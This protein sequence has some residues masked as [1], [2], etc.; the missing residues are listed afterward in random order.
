[1]SRVSASPVVDGKSEC[2]CTV[3]R[4]SSGTSDHY[5]T[6][7]SR[8]IRNTDSRIASTPSSFSSSRFLLLLHLVSLAT[9]LASS[10]P[11]AAA[12]EF[13]PVFDDI[14]RLKPKPP[15]ARVSPRRFLPPIRVPLLD[16]STRLTDHLEDSDDIR[17][18]ET[19]VHE[20]RR[21]E[22]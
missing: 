13:S 3:S 4:R 7:S 10:M 15:A 14:P 20:G 17:V 6:T 21:G 19:R 11:S 8:K 2:V 22:C 18:Q 1:M 5:S 16:E 9:L 12:L